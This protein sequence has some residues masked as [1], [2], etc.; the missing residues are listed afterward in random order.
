MQGQVRE[1]WDSEQDAYF[2]TLPWESQPPVQRV[3]GGVLAPIAYPALC[4]MRELG[5]MGNCLVLVFLWSEGPSLEGQGGK[6]SLCR[7]RVGVGL[8][9]GTGTLETDRKHCD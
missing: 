8:S 3:W 9:G 6:I 5:Y 2:L 1:L 4:Q 7:L